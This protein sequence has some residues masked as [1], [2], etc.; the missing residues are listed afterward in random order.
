M[1]MKEMQDFA[2]GI[3][4]DLREKA[5]KEAM[6]SPEFLHAKIAELE[7]DVIV[8]LDSTCVDLTARVHY[9]EGL[10]DNYHLLLRSGNKN[11]RQGVSLESF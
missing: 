3:R 2:S 9:L 1:L 10:V 8:E 6:E 5:T 4:A 7:Q 11:D